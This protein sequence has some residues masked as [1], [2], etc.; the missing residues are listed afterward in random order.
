MKDITE[1]NKNTGNILESIT[2]STKLRITESSF[3]SGFY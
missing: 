3:H 1:S 2:A